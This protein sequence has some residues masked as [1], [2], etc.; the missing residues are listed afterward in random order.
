VA[1]NTLGRVKYFLIYTVARIGLFVACWAALVG[2]GTI[3]FDDTAQV[4][5]W[6][7]FGG[8]VIS[9]VLSLKLL[10][11]PRERFAQSVQARAER[12][13]ARFEAMKNTEDV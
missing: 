2:L 4:V 6:S 3:F 7:L 1:G 5:I 8:A 13:A 12:A 10:N 9:S 11:G